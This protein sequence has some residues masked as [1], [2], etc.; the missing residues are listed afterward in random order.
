M[1]SDLS[2]NVQTHEFFYTERGVMD[3]KPYVVNAHGW[4]KP[5]TGAATVATH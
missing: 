1:Q 4:L 5:G 3:G 2:V